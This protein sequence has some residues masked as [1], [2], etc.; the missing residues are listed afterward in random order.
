MVLMSGSLKKAQ[1]VGKQPDLKV[2]MPLL[3]AYNINL[4][5]IFNS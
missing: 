5:L 4:L 3:R 1:V 2:N